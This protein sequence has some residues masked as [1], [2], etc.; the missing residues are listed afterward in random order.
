MLYLCLLGRYEELPQFSWYLQGLILHA[1]VL[2]NNV[3]NDAR[4]Q[5]CI[6]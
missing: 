1:I 6:I 4:G 5:S 2:Q 3:R